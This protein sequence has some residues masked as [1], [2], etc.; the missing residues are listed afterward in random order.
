VSDGRQPTE[1]CLDAETMAA[2]IDDRLEPS[3]R[4][5]VEAHLAKCEDCYEVWMDAVA[6]A[7]SRASTEALGSS[8]ASEH[9][10]SSFDWR[11]VIG[12]AATVILIAYLGRTVIFPSDDLKSERAIMALAQVSEAAR[13]SIG[14]LSKPF[15]YGPVRSSSRDSTAPSLSVA[16]RQQ[17]AELRVFA[18]HTRSAT[19]LRGAGIAL[20]VEGAVDEAIRTLE[21]AIVE[22]PNRVDIRVDTAAAYLERFTQ[23]GDVQDAVRS[24]EHSTFVLQKEPNST[25]A[26]FNRAV[27]LEG[28]RRIEDAIADWVRFL[29]IDSASGWADE[30]QAR[31]AKLRQPIAQRPQ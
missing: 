19:T 11:L 23:L 10:T 6:T 22:A 24:V 25:A 28:T 29:E 30:A 5:A 20:L 13:P 15:A 18:S 2:F 14:R 12:I 31:L 7:G 16:V 3:E 27:A 8:K 21:A 26:L 9:R 17:T 4:A 1:G